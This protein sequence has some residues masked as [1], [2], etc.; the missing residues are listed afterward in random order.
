M[1]AEE[2][3]N[4]LHISRSTLY[5]Y[6]KLGTIKGIK[7]SNGYYNYDENSVFAFIKKD[8]RSSVIY[9]RVAKI[10]FYNS[11]FIMFQYI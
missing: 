4:L 11:F 9:S 1:K 5:N 3:M 10:F 8:F 7:L 6:T 2:V